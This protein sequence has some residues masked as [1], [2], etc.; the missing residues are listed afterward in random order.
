MTWLALLAAGL[1]DAAATS[2]RTARVHEL[3]NRLGVRAH[4]EEPGLRN[5]LIRTLVQYPGARRTV[6]AILRGLFPAYAVESNRAYEADYEEEPE[7]SDA[8]YS[9]RHAGLEVLLPWIAAQVTRGIPWADLFWPGHYVPTSVDVPMP[10]GGSRRLTLPVAEARRIGSSAIVSAWPSFEVPT[11][12]QTYRMSKERG[13]EY[14]VVGPKPLP[15]L[16][17]NQGWPAE[18][19]EEPPAL[20]ILLSEIPGTEA[21]RPT[22]AVVSS[23]GV[24]WDRTRVLADRWSALLG[25]EASSAAASAMGQARQEAIA[26]ERP[27]GALR[28]REPYGKA[29]E[30]SIAMAQGAWQVLDRPFREA[31]LFLRHLDDLADWVQAEH[32]DLFRYTLPQALTAMAAWQATLRA[33]NFYRKAPTAS[34]Q[35]LTRWPDGATLVRLTTRE[36]LRQEGEAMGHCIGG[37]VRQGRAPG[38]GHYWQEVRDGVAMALSY[39]DARGVPQATLYGRREKSREYGVGVYLAQ[40]QGP[41]DQEIE[42]LV[43][44]RRLRGLDL[45]SL[46]APLSQQAEERLGAGQGFVWWTEE[47]DIETIFARRPDEVAT[48]ITRIRAEPF[49][50]P[51]WRRGVQRLF[52]TDLHTRKEIV[53]VP[54]VSIQGFMIV[55]KGEDLTSGNYELRAGLDGRFRVGTLWRSSTQAESRDEPFTATWTV[56]GLDSGLAPPLYVGH[57]GVYDALR[58]SG[59]LRT[60]AEDEARRAEDIAV[61]V[62][63]RGRW[64]AV[65]TYRGPG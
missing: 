41:G 8:L 37:P 39:R 27:W 20:M 38:G 42:D 60:H 7:S 33:T 49:A 51:A 14:V 58:K 32:P 26:V 55:P 11:W 59:I 53:G 30:A 6:T 15:R 16:R 4:G 61:D 64:F 56:F 22:D 50:S 34:V 43:A 48:L 62:V 63:P 25:D 13:P 54:V 5:K 19:T 36:A 10:E 29:L 3:R 9:V 23:R 1:V 65:A 28:N 21:L 18:G 17:Q 45:P 40:V 44:V 57:L 35:A 12:K 2:A 46:G 52:D 31:G 47:P 24:P